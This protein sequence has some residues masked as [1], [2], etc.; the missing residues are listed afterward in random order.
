LSA[1]GLCLVVALVLSACEKPAVAPAG[2][3]S[4]PEPV[5]VYASYTDEDYLPSLFAAF[6]AE[7]G[8]PVTVRHRDERQNVSEVIEKRGSPVADVLL[9][10]SVQGVWLAADE[11]AL[12]PL[13]SKKIPGVVPD[14]LRDPD[15]YW[16]ATGFAPI[17]VALTENADH[18][19]DEA[20]SKYEDLG[21]PEF[22]SRVCLSSSSLAVNRT[23][24]ANLIADHDVRP[25]E[26]IVRGWIANLALPPFESEQE[27]LQ[28]IEAS[29]C[30]VGVVS[31]VAFARFGKP[32]IAARLPVPGYVDLEAVGIGRHARSPDA[33]RRL[34]EWF[35][36]RDTQVAHSAGSGLL[37]ANAAALAEP[38]KSLNDEGRR[39]GGVAG[40]NEVDAVKLAER[41][42]WR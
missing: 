35:I 26:I 24:I 17:Y 20:I 34:V 15:G 16:T 6:T 23:L 7:T 42:A 14:W 18:G 37:P 10:R 2:P 5:V 12:L 36:A 31:G 1:R 29:T 41:A 8:I 22:R 13:Q 9:T 33:A 19:L 4:R 11:G 39:N 28:A 3:E 38:Y 40:L 25:A 32:G 27:L 30:D 21:K